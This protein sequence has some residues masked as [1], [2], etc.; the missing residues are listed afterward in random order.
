VKECSLVDIPKEVYYSYGGSMYLQVASGQVEFK[1]WNLR[2]DLAATSSP[3]GAY[4]PAPLTDAF[5]DTVAGARPT[6]DWNGAWGYRNEALTGG[7]QKVGVR[8]YDPTVGRFLQQDPWLGSVYAPPTLNAYGYC[9]NDPISMVDALGMQPHQVVCPNC[10][11]AFSPPPH[12]GGFEA[13]VG[14]RD[15]T[16]T[17]W[18]DI[19]ADL[20]NRGPAVGVTLPPGSPGYVRC[21]YRLPG[22]LSGTGWGGLGH[23]FK[24]FDEWRD[25]YIWW[26]DN[27]RYIT[28]VPDYWWER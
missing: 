17:V 22:Q 9:V 20:G 27:A 19:P 1:H 14:F 21:G 24:E 15:P 11:H 23:S 2:G 7:L 26:E 8:W 16:G 13:S 10:G 25:R 6:Y 5:G 12:P 3:T 4:A 28:G 18:I